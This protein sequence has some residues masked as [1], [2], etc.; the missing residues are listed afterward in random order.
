MEAGGGGRLRKLDWERGGGGGERAAG[1]EIVQRN[2]GNENQTRVDENI[3]SSRI[4]DTN[5]VAA[6]RY[7]GDDWK[8]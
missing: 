8:N 1:G 2:R 6:V 7:E 4:G 5:R 3:Q